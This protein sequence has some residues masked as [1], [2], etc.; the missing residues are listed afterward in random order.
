MPTAAGPSPDDR[1]R[2]AASSEPSPETVA[3]LAEV[4]PATLSDDGRLSYLQAVERAQAWLSSLTTEPIVNMVGP[5]VLADTEDGDNVDLHQA[6]VREEIRLA[7]ALSRPG[8]EVRI[9]VAMQLCG[10]L[11]ATQAALAA[12]TITFMHART[13]VEAV[14][15]LDDETAVAIEGRVLPKCIDRPL[16]SLRRALRAALASLDA[17]QA[18][19]RHERAAAT[20]AVRRWNTE[21][22]MAE[23]AITAPAPD[24]HLI[25]QALTI[26]AGTS[27][28]VEGEAVDPRS[29]DARRVDAL[30]RV[31]LD[32]VVPSSSTPSTGS[33]HSAPRRPRVPI[34][35]Q[36]VIDL[37][38]LV[39]LADNPAELR[40][41]GPIPA[42]VA[43][44]WLTDAVSW[45]RLVT[46]PVDDHLLDLGPI[47]RRPP[48]ALESF[49]KA[50]DG[51]C[52]FPLCHQPA[53][54]CDLDHCEPHRADGSG[55]STSASNLGALC[56]YHHRLKTFMGWQP[57]VEGDRGL[58]W[59]SPTGRTYP[60]PARPQRI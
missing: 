28:S 51:T 45:R 1:V 32:A 31:C 41:Y 20:R 47:V 55:G 25:W 13:L 52:T 22:G 60:V 58:V 12:G 16:S 26:L 4:N 23:L 24:I 39:G 21:D 38:T 50:R 15:G 42:D 37:P 46:D 49:V 57:T 33:E 17:S 19:E 29:L 8:A 34:Q 44:L 2:R 14:V 54:R 9:D 6:S 56:R 5:A 35:A 11:T 59:R 30:T 40:G 53:D 48:P 43:R 18:V 36:V 7:L 27:D 3:V 10:R